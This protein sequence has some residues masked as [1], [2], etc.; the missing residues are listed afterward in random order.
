LV[1]FAEYA[2]VMMGKEPR[3]VSIMDATEG[4]INSFYKL[5]GMESGNSISINLIL[6]NE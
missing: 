4:N 2:R 1:S 6:I 3:D 5:L